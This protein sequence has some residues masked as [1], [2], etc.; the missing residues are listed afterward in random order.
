VCLGCEVMGVV[1]ISAIMGAAAEVVDR[2]GKQCEPDSR[3]CCTVGIDDDTLKCIAR[4]PCPC[5]R[6]CCRRQES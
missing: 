1:C 2:S 4:G 3:Q 5:Q 6:Q